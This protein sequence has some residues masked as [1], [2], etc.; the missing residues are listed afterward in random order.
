MSLNAQT[1]VGLW[2]NLAGV[3]AAEPVELGIYRNGQLMTA[4]VPGVT[5]TPVG[6]LGGWM[7]RLHKQVLVGRATSGLTL[8]VASRQTSS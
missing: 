3:G 1:R 5:A 6:G 7:A 8:P 4:L 2:N